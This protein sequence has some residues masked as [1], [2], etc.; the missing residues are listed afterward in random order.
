MV[1]NYLQTKITVRM[2][3]EKRRRKKEEI[4]MSRAREYGL[5][6]RCVALLYSASLSGNYDSTLQRSKAL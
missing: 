1:K 2:R 6:F 4:F 3:N 5:N